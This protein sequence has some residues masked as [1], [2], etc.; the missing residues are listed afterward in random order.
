[1][2][3]VS[4]KPSRQLAAVV[5]A[6]HVAA[7]MTL[8]PLDVPVWAKLAVTLLI[9]ASLGHTLR[10]HA[11]LAN[12]ASITALEVRENDSGAIQTR[13]EDWQEARI[14]GTSYVS[15]LL[16]VVNMRVTGCRL[17]YHILIVPDNVDAEGFRRLR[18]LLRWGYRKADLGS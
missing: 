10:R 4:L 1:M 7:A 9:A 5:M 17:A 8:L 18:V 12:G 13:G 15:P 3:R 6:A 14:L 11:L 2:L 16:T